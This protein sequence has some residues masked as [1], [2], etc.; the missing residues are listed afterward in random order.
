M[1]PFPDLTNCTTFPIPECTHLEFKRGFNSCPQDKIIATLCALLNSGGGYLVVGVEDGTRTIVGFTADKIMDFFLL[2]IDNIYHIGLIK[3]MNGLPLSVNTIKTSIVPA[4]NDK[5][6]YVI[7]TVP[8]DG[9]KYCLKDGSVWYRLAASNYKQTAIQSVYT[10][11]EMKTI[12][13]QRLTNQKASHQFEYEKLKTKFVA[14]EREFTQFMDAAKQTEATLQ[15]FRD[16]MFSHIRQQKDAV[17]VKLCKKRRPW[18][19]YL[20]CCRETMA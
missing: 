13:N 12:L 17:E 20:F 8:E 18:Y 2:A 5:N 15:E 19:M 6:V 11:Q 14:L 4:Y 3:N 7:T 9:A 1:F 16:L 10:E